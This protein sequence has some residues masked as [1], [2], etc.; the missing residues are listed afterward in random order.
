MRGT[1]LALAVLV[2]SAG[3]AAQPA[4]HPTVLSFEDAVARALAR[5]P[6]VG[7]AAQE[8]KRA[9]ALVEQARSSSL[10][11][12]VGNVSYTLLD[13]NRALG[14]VIIAPQNQV[15]AS[16]TVTVPLA[17]PQAWVRW[18]H[19]LDAVDVAQRS[20]ADVRRQL[21]VA[22]AKTY[23][24]LVAQHRV[25]D[26]TDRAAANARAHYDYAHARFAG[27]FGNRVDEVRAS[28]ELASDEAALAAAHS[29]LYALQEALGVLL[30]EDAPFDAE[31]EAKLP[32]PP[33]VAAALDEV[34]KLRTDVLLA[35]ERL[36]AARHVSRDDWADYVPSLALSGMPFYANPPTVTQPTTG[37]Q[38]QLV[39]SWTIY[40]GGLR[41]GQAKE[42][43]TLEAEAELNLEGTVR[44]ARSDVRAAAVAL[45]RAQE[46]LLSAHDASAKAQQALVLTNLA[47]RAGATTN[48]EVVDAERAALDADTAAAVAEDAVRQAHLDTLVAAGQFP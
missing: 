21:A 39:L 19:A 14:G 18:A 26:V 31:P 45:D 34:P 20:E 38:L 36:V 8:V 7:V 5:N 30:G 35:D 12:L 42:R 29:A 46:A 28:Q 3:A 25:I 11:T 48:I 23:L 44:Q 6:T 43:A 9:V 33:S 1:E 10:P 17:V 40:D 16:A 27:G 41:Y 13:G 37:W 2:W 47:Y 32:P 22:V 4:G 15:I 24:S